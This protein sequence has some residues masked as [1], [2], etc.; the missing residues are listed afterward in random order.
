MCVPRGGGARSGAVLQGSALARVFHRV[1]G[2]VDRVHVDRV[3]SALGL[4]A[5]VSPGSGRGRLCSQRARPWCGCP[6]GC[7]RALSARVRVR[8]RVVDADARC[9]HR[10]GVVDIVR[11][12]LTPRGGYNAR[13][14]QQRASVPISHADCQQRASVRTTRAHADNARRRP[15]PEPSSAVTAV[16]ARGPR[17]RDAVAAK[18]AVGNHGPQSASV[19]NAGAAGRAGPLARHRP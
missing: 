12:L 6:L 16:R 15:S 11:G 7:G 9:R 3:R 13:W 5:G 1:V 2:V 18:V 19:V 10:E 17:R 4:S 14:C 8:A